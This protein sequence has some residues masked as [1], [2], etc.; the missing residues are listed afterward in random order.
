MFT[1]YSVTV[2]LLT[3]GIASF[4]QAQQS[5]S[6]TTRRDSVRVR[7]ERALTTDTTKL[8]LD[9]A[10]LDTARTLLEKDRTLAQADEKRIDSLRTVLTH[11]QQK[12]DSAAVAR[13]KAAIL[14]LRKKMDAA[15]DRAQREEHRVEV[16]QKTVR[17]ET[18]K[19][20]ETR[21]D[22]KQDKPGAKSVSKKKS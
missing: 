1:R 19:T 9:R 22:I 13:D 10:R 12:G 11:D 4:A 18:G 5:S 17:R 21:Q 2:A 15:Q 6:D 8:R 7:D 3:L 20:M 16:A 14:A